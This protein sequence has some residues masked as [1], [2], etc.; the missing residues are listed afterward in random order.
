MATAG[1]VE[2]AARGLGA[3]DRVDDCRAL[4]CD[5]DAAQ[6]PLF[7]LHT[8]ER[9]GQ[10]SRLFL[11]LFFQRTHPALSEFALSARLQHGAAP[12]FLAVPFAVVVP[13]ERVFPGCREAAFP[14]RGPL[15]AHETT[16]PVLGGLPACVLHFLLH[17]G[18]LFDA[19]LSSSGAATRLG[20]HGCL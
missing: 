4:A 7:R 18:V 14:R 11:V 2:T 12:V 15:L 1:D 20:D 9:P 19:V 17:T 8:F 16:V 3:A 5:R 10:L 6:S 13:M